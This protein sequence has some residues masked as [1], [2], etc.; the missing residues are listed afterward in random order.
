MWNLFC[1]FWQFYYVCPDILQD[2]AENCTNNVYKFITHIFFDDIKSELSRRLQCVLFP[3]F[4]L[5]FDIPLIKFVKTAEKGTKC[6]CFRVVEDPR[7]ISK[8]TF[9]FTS[10]RAHYLWS[11]NWHKYIDYI[12]CFL[13]WVADFISFK[14]SR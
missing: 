8:H 1:L 9:R 7:H 5:S 14:P 2:V 4:M 13:S 11:L 10:S 6:V 3:C 12:T